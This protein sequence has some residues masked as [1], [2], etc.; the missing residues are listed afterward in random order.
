MQRPRKVLEQEANRDQVKE[1]PESAGDA[2]MRFAFVPVDVPDGNLA[3]AGAI[4]RRQ[5]GNKAV[6]ALAIERNL[7]DQFAAVSLVG[8][9]EIV[10]IDAAQLR[11]QP[12]GATRRNA[13]HHQIV[14]AHLAPAAHNVVALINFFDEG[15]NV[16]RIV[17]QIA[18]HGDDVLAL[19]MV[20]TGRQ[21]RGL[22]EV[23]AQL[24]H[25]DAAVDGG[26]FPQQVEGLIA[27]AIVDEDQLEAFARRFHHGRQTV[28][29]FGDALLL[30]VKRNNNGKLKHDKLIIS[31][32][33]GSG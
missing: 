31:S 20:E 5:G 3:D 11:H 2:V 33:S 25:H 13:P 14:D 17:L 22:A 19:G 23:P 30:I 24:H 7:L 26:D 8:G 6:H 12:V 15:R 10:Q 9:A 21:S 16:V 18:V 28:I 27:A 1:N 4:P 29:E 32:Q